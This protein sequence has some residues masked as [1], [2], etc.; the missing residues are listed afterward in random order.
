MQF[1]KYMGS[2]KF[3]Q[4]ASA[5]E[6]HAVEGVIG[7]FIRR[8]VAPQGSWMSTVNAAVIEAFER[9]AAISLGLSD[10]TG[11]NPAAEKWKEFF[12][13]RTSGNLTERT[14][15]KVESTRPEGTRSDR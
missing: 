14:V 9:G 8:H 5:D 11:G 15:S 3:P 13:Q 7:F 2:K 1:V 6:F 10:E 12:D 4:L